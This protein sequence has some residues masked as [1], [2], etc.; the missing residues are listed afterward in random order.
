MCPKN[1]G[2]KYDYPFVSTKESGIRVTDAGN[3][4]Q[5][6]FKLCINI[7]RPTMYMIGLVAHT[8]PFITSDIQIRFCLMMATAIGRP[9]N[10]C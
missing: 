1:K 2:Y 3:V 10:K 8:S 6:L 4:V 5:P 7:E 9:K